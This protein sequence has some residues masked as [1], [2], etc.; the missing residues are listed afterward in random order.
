METLASHSDLTGPRRGMR[1]DGPEGPI[2]LPA[3]R[4]P[5]AQ[6]KSTH[7]DTQNDAQE[8]L[9]REHPQHR[10]H[11]A[12]RRRQDDDDRAH[13]LLHRPH[14]QAR[15]GPRGRGDDGL[16]GTGAGARHHDHLCRDDGGVEG[17]PHQHHRHAR[18]TWTSRSRSSARCASST[19]RSPL[20][21]SVAGVEPQSETVWRQADKY[22]VPRIAYINKMDRVGAELRAGRADD[23]RPPRRAPRADPAPDRRRGGLRRRRSTWC[24]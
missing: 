19:A 23:G 8:I 18:A 21:D 2:F 10:D 17:P 13:P 4:R 22:G 14:L 12:H 7:S 1:A 3:S 20:F 16:D 5:T 11:G 9:T 6:V 24:A 15:R